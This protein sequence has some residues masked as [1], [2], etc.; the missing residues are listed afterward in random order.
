MKAF[1]LVE[2]ISIFLGRYLDNYTIDQILLCMIR[3]SSL[4]KKIVASASFKATNVFIKHTSFYPKIMN[5]LNLSMNEK[6]SQIRLYALGY[7]KTLLQ[8]H[9][10]RD[11]TRQFMDRTTGVM[12]HFEN[13]ITKG[14]NDPTP[15]VK[16][17]CR[18][19]FWIFCEH[20]K[21]RG[22]Q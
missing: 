21:D 4:T 1:L 17:V 18:E 6:N 8:T 14:L 10:H 9:A 15:A 11:S 7:I 16:E 12:D 22:D 19:A 13:I 2:D 20:W 3:C 5:M